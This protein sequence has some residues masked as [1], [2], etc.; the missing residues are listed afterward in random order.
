M[1][2]RADHALTAGKSGSGKSYYTGSKFEDKILDENAFGVILDPK[3]HGGDHGAMSSALGFAHVHITSDLLADMEDPED[4]FSQMIQGVKAQG[5]PGIRF[6]FEDL[7]PDLDEYLPGFADTIARILLGLD[8]NVV[9]LIE[10][11][12]NFCPHENRGGSNKEVSGLLKYFEEGRS[13]GKTAM[14]CTQST[15]KILTDVFDA[16]LHFELFYM[17]PSE[18]HYTK[19]LDQR[20]GTEREYIQECQSWNTGDRNLLHKDDHTGEIYVEN[21]DGLERR[22][23]HDG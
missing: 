12:Q 22:T 18:T 13:H 9:L 5:I 10:E 21:V 11:L 23:P 15:K 20:D 16:F 14:A 7:D 6:T 8:G 2:E 4:V 17:G 3:D 19:V 1:S